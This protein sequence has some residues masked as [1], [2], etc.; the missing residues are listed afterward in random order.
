[1]CFSQSELGERVGSGVKGRLTGIED[2]SML[3]LWVPEALQPIV[4]D[5]EHKASV[6]HT[7]GGLEI[8]MGADGPVVQKQHAL[9]GYRDGGLGVLQRRSHLAVLC[10]QGSLDE[11]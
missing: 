8:P 6:H 3:R 11:P 2:V 1:M 4:G 10:T 9:G 7:V 5:L